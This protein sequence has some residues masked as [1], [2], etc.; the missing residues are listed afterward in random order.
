MIHPCEKKN[1]EFTNVFA[2][3]WKGKYSINEN[4]WIQWVNKVLS[5]F[6][7]YRYRHKHKM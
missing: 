3:H 5:F 1:T 7:F 6:H 2:K 4:V